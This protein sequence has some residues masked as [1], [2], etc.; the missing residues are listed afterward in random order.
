VR[1]P[2]RDARSDPLARSAGALDAAALRIV[3]RDDAARTYSDRSSWKC[4]I[5][6]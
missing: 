6:A 5:D 4:T 2:E 3:E 1:L